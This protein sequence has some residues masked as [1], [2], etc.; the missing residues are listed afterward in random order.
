MI[1]L[2]TGGPVLGLLPEARYEQ[3]QCDVR[4]GDLIVL[5]SDG[6]IEAV[7]AAGEEYGESRLHRSLT[8]IQAGNPHDIRA[9]I[10]SSAGAF[11]GPAP[12]RDDLTLVVAKF[13]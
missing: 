3:A 10:L 5:Y 9:A 11:L 6:L 8:T 7:N 2:D 12:P 4:P 13:A 1:R